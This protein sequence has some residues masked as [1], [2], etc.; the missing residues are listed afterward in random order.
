MTLC[1]IDN[2]SGFSRKFEWQQ[3]FMGQKLPQSPSLA[4]GNR[5]MGIKN[6]RYCRHFHVPP[7]FQSSSK[8]QVFGNLFAFFSPLSVIYW[9]GKIYKMAGFFFN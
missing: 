4:F 5:F 9:N 1:L 3:I 7:Y 2:I 6:N 8:N